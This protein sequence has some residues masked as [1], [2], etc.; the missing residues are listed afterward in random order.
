MIDVLHFERRSNLSPVRPLSLIGKGEATNAKFLYRLVSCAPKLFTEA[1]V[2]V[3]V[4]NE[5][6]IVVI[7]LVHFFLLACHC[8]SSSKQ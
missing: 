4:A 6:V 8:Q 2:E 3:E 7:Q 1:Q 5:R